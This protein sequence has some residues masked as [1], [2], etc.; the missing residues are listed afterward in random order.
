VVVPKFRNVTA[1]AGLTT[2]VPDAGCT[3]VVTGA[4]WGD[5]DGDGRLDLFL[6]RLDQP[7]QLFRSLGGGRFAEQAEQRR[8]Q[9]TGAIGASFAD[10]DND[11]RADLYIVRI[12][13]DVLLH[14]DGAG[15]TDVT[16]RA[17]IADED[18]GSSAS[19]GDF[20][21]DGYL[22]LYVTNY[23]GCAKTPFR[24]PFDETFRYEPDRLY[25]NNR[26]GTFTNVSSILPCAA[27]PTDCADGTLGAG[28][29][30][31]W[32]DA[33]GD[34][35]PDLYLG[36][37]YIGP[38]PDGNRLWLNRGRGAD[39]RWHFDDAS[40]TSGTAY[41][42]ATMGVGIGDYNRD[43]RFDIALS[44]VRFNVLFRNNGNGTFT[45]V[46]S[47]LGVARR[48]NQ[49][50][51]SIPITWAVAFYDFNGD[52]WEDL[53]FAA[54]N[55]NY[56][57]R[58]VNWPQ[59]NQLF[60]NDRKGGFNDVSEASG[61]ADPGESKGAAFADFDRDGRMDIFVVNQNGQPNLFR[62]VTPRGNR[63][64]LGVRPVGTRSNRD[65]C[66][67]RMVLTTRSGSM[68]RE[69][70]CGSISVASGH[71]PAVLFGLGQHKKVLKLAIVWPSGRRQV[72]RDLTKID[73]YMTLV[74]PR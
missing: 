67:T 52:G 9:V 58:E 46:A 55:L 29:Q 69:V 1:Q 65:A 27:P 21:D 20:D 15:F 23:V 48:T 11:G 54:G 18:L 6:A 22:D 16:A 35:R 51:D 38:N 7:T 53:Y 5:V 50:T 40:K 14:N 34:G 19:W 66:G 17:G 56:Q 73:R 74:E 8:A 31:S 45:D 63:H 39:G 25:H 33:N 37:D 12:G 24:G 70:F 72:L 28:F 64:W 57:V 61:A 44:N 43:L 62:N 2:T 41:K 4:A 71:D 36:N 47:V 59:P 30:A 10:Y 13:S 3:T 32:F 68:L 60:L 49:R 42:M 26:D